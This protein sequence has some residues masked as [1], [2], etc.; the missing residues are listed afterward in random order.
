[1]MKYNGS[2]DKRTPQEKRKKRCALIEARLYLEKEN[3]TAEGPLLYQSLPLIERKRLVY[4]TPTT[5]GRLGICDLPKSGIFRIAGGQNFAQDPECALGPVPIASPHREEAIGNHTPTTEARLEICD[6]PKSGIFRIAGG[7]NFAQD[8]ECALG[9]VPI[10]SPHR[11][12]AIG[13]PEG[14][15]S[16]RIPSVRWDRYQSLPLIERKRLVY[17]TP[18]TEGRLEICDLPKSGIFRIAG[19]QNFAQDPECAL[20]PVPIASSHREEAIGISHAPNG[21]P[22]ENFPL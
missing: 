19:G 3:N 11:E 5:E 21:G 4:H 17:H 10:A 8:P 9:P 13:L 14:K 22:T 20:G 16:R 15:T 6:L 18:P 12:E 2:L 1:M 7:Q